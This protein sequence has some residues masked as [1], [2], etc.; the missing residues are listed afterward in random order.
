MFQFKPEDVKSGSKFFEGVFTATVSSHMF[1]TND[2]DGNWVRNDT[3]DPYDPN[4]VWDIM[5]TIG[6]GKPQSISLFGGEPFE[7]R[8]HKWASMFINCNLDPINSHP[9]TI[10]GK[11]IKVLAYAEKPTTEGNVW[12]RLWNSTFDLEVDDA[13]V[14]EWF[15]KMLASAKD[16]NRVKKGINPESKYASGRKPTPSQLEAPPVAQAAHVEVTASPDD[17][18][19]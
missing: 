6:T 1:K 9:D 12:S 15:G 5:V 13:K 16:T 19:W 11:S 17:D 7:G 8:R 18:K 3:P 4:T 2:G 10:L 14:E